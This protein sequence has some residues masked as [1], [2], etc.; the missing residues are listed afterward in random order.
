MGIIQ[1]CKCKCKEKKNEDEVNLQKNLNVQKADIIVNN[2]SNLKK[3]DLNLEKLFNK[4]I[5]IEEKKEDE[6]SENFNSEEINDYNFI[7]VISINDS[8]FIKE[9]KI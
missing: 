8:S 3:L 4:R 2:L 7:N 9:K 5:K 1:E 6:I